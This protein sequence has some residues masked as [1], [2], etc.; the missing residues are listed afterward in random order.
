M[1]DE[2]GGIA[3]DH[4]ISQDGTES[5]PLDAF[6]NSLGNLNDSRGSD[7]EG[8]GYGIASDGT[9]DLRATYLENDPQPCCM[10]TGA[11]KSSTSVPADA[12][13]NDRCA[14]GNSLTRSA[15]NTTSTEQGFKDI[16]KVDPVVDGLPLPEVVKF[17]KRLGVE[18]M[19]LRVPKPICSFGNLGSTVP[20]SLMRRFDK[21]GYVEPMP[22]QCQAMPVLLQ[23]R[24][25]ILMGE[26]GCG[27][28]LS[29]LVP[30]VCHV[31]SLI[32]DSN[33][34][35]LKRS[36]FCI[37]VG[38]TREACGQIYVMLSKLLKFVSVRVATVA[39]GYDNYNQVISGTEFLIVTPAKLSDLVNR[40]CLSLG[41]THAVAL[42]EFPKVY[43]K[44][45]EEAEMLLRL[46]AM[47]IIV[48]NVMLGTDTL[49]TLRQYLKN[50][51]TVK[52]LITPS[53]SN[54]NIKWISCL[55]EPSRVQK[56]MFVSDLL[57][58]FHQAF[59]MV[60]FAN[61]KM[62]VEMIHGFIKN[63]TESVKYI[64][65]EVPRDVC[66][67]TMELFRSGQ[68]Q[69]LVVT[70]ALCRNINLPD[71]DYVI[72]FDMPRT[73]SK[74]CA[75]V[76]TVQT[77]K[78]G[79]V[80]S[81]LTKQDHIVSAHICYQL[82]NDGLDVPKVLEQVA[83][84]WK[85]YRD[86]KHS[87]TGLGIQPKEHREVELTMRPVSA[88]DSFGD[89]SGQEVLISTTPGPSAM[90]Q[91]ALQDSVTDGAGSPG[92]EDTGREYGIDDLIS[93][94]EEEDIVPKRQLVK[95]AGL[96]DFEKVRQRRL[97]MSQD[98]L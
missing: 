30:L 58:H 19:G 81:L 53:L 49:T 94:D 88:K 37:I 31:L 15:S 85:P 67:S 75:R 34:A 78:S 79:V 76:R 57:S 4:V 7:V 84:N 35:A 8:D 55:K 98:Q 71:I 14:G 42:E 93:S 83:S 60:I 21:L 86:S 52:Y 38:L 39:S 32:R 10:D 3:Q 95:P 64:H 46:G 5:D 56:T 77:S 47:K 50:S 16:Y 70:D 51:V 68:L 45:P 9:G 74:F 43:Q 22:M 59:R 23:G 90:V 96:I 40:R 92:H 1:G 12:L 82:V 26:S 24:N 6:L 61:D 27:K 80:Y 65:E 87:G 73:L 13:Q 29:Y 69:I 25:A 20:Q 17:K 66:S 89:K 63:I 54:I 97:K 11:S 91:A 62:T 36:A 33:A 2:P 41:S 18:T 28:T 72:V 44:H 48:S